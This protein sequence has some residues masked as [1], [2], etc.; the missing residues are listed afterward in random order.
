MHNVLPRNERELEMWKQFHPNAI[1]GPE[2][3]ELL[4]RANRREIVG[5][6]YQ[7]DKEFAKGMEKLMG[8]LND[9]KSDFEQL[10]EKIDKLINE[11]EKR[12]ITQT[13]E[14]AKERKAKREKELVKLY[15]VFH[16]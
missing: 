1:Y 14:E 2:K 11:A 15:K 5:A 8:K 10:I 16:S 9:K 6:Y 3:E 7:V 12:L 4:R 13:L